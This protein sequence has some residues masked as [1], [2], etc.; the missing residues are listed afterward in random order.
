MI[1]MSELKTI[2]YAGNYVFGGGVGQGKQIYPE[3]EEL[4]RGESRVSTVAVDPADYDAF[5]LSYSNARNPDGS[6]RDYWS[7]VATRPED[8]GS[9]DEAQDSTELDDE[10]LSFEVDMP[11]RYPLSESHES[12]VER[13]YQT[14][15]EAAERFLGKTGLKI[16]AT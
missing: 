14:L 4:E 3:F 1:S 2:I 11:E 5:A 9:D 6:R 12:Y 16:I 13:N 7:V 8:N 15:A 10:A